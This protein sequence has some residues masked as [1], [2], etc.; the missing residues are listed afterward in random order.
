MIKRDGILYVVK[1]IGYHIYVFK[2]ETKRDWELLS[3]S[4]IKRI[5]NWYLNCFFSFFF[6][7]DNHE[8]LA[9]SNWML[10]RQNSRSSICPPT[11]PSSIA[12]CP[13]IFNIFQLLSPVHTRR[14]SYTSR[15]STQSHRRMRNY[16]AIRFS[17]C[18]VINIMTFQF[19]LVNSSLNFNSDS[20]PL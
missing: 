13:V 3:K 14:I 20:N 16:V 15:V 9:V 18:A 7:N 4:S 8:W 19:D 1:N 12:S 10:E 17:H 11:S 5:Y 2:I 6:V